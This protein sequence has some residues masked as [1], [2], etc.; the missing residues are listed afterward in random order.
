MS[1]A[2]VNE[3]CD[4]CGTRFRDW[5]PCY[6]T[7]PQEDSDLTRCDGPEHSPARCRDVLKSMVT[8]LEAAVESALS[9]LINGADV[10][11]V[12]ATSEMLKPDARAEVERWDLECRTAHAKLMK[13]RALSSTSGPIPR[14]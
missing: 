9:P 2:S 11:G 10:L 6:Y 7:H 12:I 3:A 8:A 1:A 5:K 14:S 4:H 13:V